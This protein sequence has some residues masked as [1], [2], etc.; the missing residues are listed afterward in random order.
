M[1]TLSISLTNSWRVLKVVLIPT[2]CLLIL[3]IQLI[4]RQE[5]VV[6]QV[7]SLDYVKTVEDWPY[8][9]KYARWDV[10]QVD[11][12]WLKILDKILVPGCNIVD[13]GANTGDTSLVLAVASRGGTVAAFEMGTPIQMLR[14]NKRYIYITIPC[15]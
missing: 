7:L 14:V 11:W 3:G 5:D 8:G 10:G 4:T 9:I 13:I 15:V 1:N 12:N 2:V 6:E